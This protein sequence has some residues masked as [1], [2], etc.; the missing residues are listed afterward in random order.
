[1]TDSE[2]FFFNQLNERQQRL[3]AGLKSSNIGYHGVSEVSKEL[4]LHPHTVRLGQ[5][6][7]QNQILLPNNGVRK[8]GGGRKKKLRATLQ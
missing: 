2:L 4:G 6:E 5:K 8:E 1:M 3:Y 7:L